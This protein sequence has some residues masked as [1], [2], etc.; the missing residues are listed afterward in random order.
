MMTSVQT[1]NSEFCI[2]GFPNMEL[3][4]SSVMSI[5]FF[6]LSILLAYLYDFKRKDDKEIDSRGLP[7]DYY[8][9]MH[10][11]STDLSKNT[12]ATIVARKKGITNLGND[13]ISKLDAKVINLMYN[14]SGM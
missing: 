9:V 7:Y 12:R 2:T 4:K 10:F 1:N 8:S 14:C 5:H 11:G 3:N 6:I 13:N